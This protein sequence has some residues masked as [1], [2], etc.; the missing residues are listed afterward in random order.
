MEESLDHLI[1]SESNDS[2]RGGPE[3]VGGTATV[4]PGESFPVEHLPDA[5]S[6]TVVLFHCVLLMSL[7]LKPCSYHLR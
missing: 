1:A 7:F 5:V 4:E 6:H 2:S 3:E